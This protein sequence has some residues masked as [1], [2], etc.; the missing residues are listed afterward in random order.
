MNKKSKIF[1]FSLLAVN[2]IIFILDLLPIRFEFFRI[3]FGISLIVIGLS[4]LVRALSL[5]IDSSM[6]MGI[7]LIL[8]G[9]LN[10]LAFL[11]GKTNGVDI[12]EF[13]PYYLFAV[14]VASLVT[15]IYF[16]DK[17]QYK[18]SILFLGFGLITLLFIKKLIVL[19]AFIVLLILWF[20]GYFTINI[21]LT[22]RRR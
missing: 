22:K 4:L 7:I 6:F 10:I 16:K 2:V 8:C 19:W 1:Y 21:I 11:L 3:S 17:L 20:I 18:V 9:V 13:W 15:A 12:N 5:K 14:S